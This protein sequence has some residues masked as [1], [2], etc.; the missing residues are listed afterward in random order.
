MLITAPGG[1]TG[2]PLMVTQFAF[3]AWFTSIRESQPLHT[4]R[5]PATTWISQQSIWTADSQILLFSVYIPPVPMHIPDEVSAQPALTAIQ[6]TITITLQN[7]Q[8]PTSVMLS[9]DFNRHHPAWG[10]NHIQPWFV[11]DASELIDFFQVYGLHS[12]LPRGTV[13]FWSLSHP[14]RNS[15]IDQTVMDQ[16]D[17]LV[18]CHLYHENYRSDH[19]TTYSEWSLRARCNPTTKARK[20]YG[21][22]DWDKIGDE[23]LWKIGP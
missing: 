16:P 1:C 11:E 22:S 23:V 10:G 17:L 9:G 15:T 3:T 5:S 14:G 4:D 6:N 13:T 2:Q 8:R 18:K 7:D 19:C 12:C 21:H 20:A